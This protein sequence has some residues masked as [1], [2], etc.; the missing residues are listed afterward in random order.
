MERCCGSVLSDFILMLRY[1]TA[2]CHPGRNYDLGS[3]PSPPQKKKLNF[4]QLAI[5][6]SITQEFHKEV[7]K[8][9]IKTV[10]MSN[11]D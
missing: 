4:M 1:P 8:E 10:K 7:M 2:S 11:I 9:N 3:P 6:N 5:L